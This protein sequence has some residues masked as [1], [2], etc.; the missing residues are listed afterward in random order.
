MRAGTSH[1]G[2]WDSS[3]RTVLPPFGNRTP[4]KPTHL[5]LG[6]ETWCRQRGSYLWGERD[7]SFDSLQN[8]LRGNFPHPL[9]PVNT[10][11]PQ[12]VPR[13]RAA[14]GSQKSLCSGTTLGPPSGEPDIFQHHLFTCQILHVSRMHL[15][16]SMGSFRLSTGVQGKK[17]FKP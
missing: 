17:S 8:N 15:K 7:C 4:D 9:L 2:G 16:K 6:E 3:P 10:T 12:A 1:P 14:H 13:G 5:Q 11:R